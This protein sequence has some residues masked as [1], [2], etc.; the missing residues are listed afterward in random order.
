MTKRTPLLKWIFASFALLIATTSCNKDLKD[1]VD[2][3]KNRVTTLEESVNLL[4][5]AI[6]NGKLI[7]D[8]SPVAPTSTTPGGWLITFSDKTTIPVNHGSKGDTGNTGAT[9]PQG[10][11]PYVWVNNAGNWASNLGSKPVDADNPSYEIKQGGKSVKA[12]GISV[13]VI[14]KDG[15][16]AFEE[17]DVITNTVKN[18]V[19]TTFPFVG[20]KVITAIVETPESVT[21]TID[22]KTYCLAK[23]A[24]FPTSITVIRDKDYVIKGGTVKFDIA[25]NPANSKIYT[26]EDFSLDYEKNYTRAYGL[27]PDFIKIK[28]VEPYDRDGDYKGQYHMT[29]E[30]KESDAGFAKDAAIF[31]VL[32]CTDVEGKLTHI[33]S[34]TPVIMNEKYVSIDDENVKDLEGI[35]M[36]SDETFTDSIYLQEYHQGYVNTITYALAASPSSD[37]ISINPLT[38]YLVPGGDKYKFTV[39]P[40][41]GDNTTVWPTGVYQRHTDV[42]VS[43]S[44]H[45]RAAV[46]AVPAK[47]EIGQPA[48]PGIPEIPA[49]TV[50]KDFCVTVYKVPTDGII[51]TK[52]FQDRWLPN[53]TVDYTLTQT[54]ATAFNDN[55][56][57]TTDWTFAIKTQDLQLH[58]GGAWASTTMD[59]KVAADVTKFN[60]NGS[61]AVSYKLL[62]TIDAG[63]YQMILTITATSKTVRPAEMKQSREFK[64][65]LQFNV[66]APKFQILYKGDH[67]LIGSGSDTYET[68]VLKDVNVSFLFDVES[69]KNISKATDVTPNATPLAYDYDLTDPRHGAQGIRFNPYPAVK[70]PVVADWGSL[71]LIK[72][73]ITANVKLA[74]GQSL[75]VNIL[76]TP[77]NEQHS[78]SVLYVQYTRLNLTLVTAAKEDFVGNYNAMV[79]TGINIAAS[80]NFTPKATGNKTLDPTMIKTIAYSAI[81]NVQ[82]AGALPNG[83]AGKQI[84]KVDAATGM[85][86]S[87]DGISWE[88]PDA[89]LF[90]V[91]RVTYTDIWGNSAFK[92]VKV[93]VKSN[94]IPSLP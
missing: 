15:Y 61:F 80:S 21:F 40:F 89:I 5:Q 6:K 56:Y 54:L 50:D 83:L 87:I 29:L 34:S 20:G 46:P 77:T 37:P 43:V 45:G 67:T 92:D 36:F 23:A 2:E 79:T 26:K 33:V 58:S 14:N 71:M 28:S 32:N 82:S 27:D 72:K 18:T 35:V 86:T 66:V 13:R 90:Q 81:G 9:G 48:T 64:V 75:P 25:V 1:D 41:R 57:K 74:T 88:N 44:D 94:S 16:V 11:T 91:F 8:V 24:V 93:H 7:T 49:K 38:R 68:T 65:K 76:C 12:N 51:L 3:L 52:D 42:T 4:D 78:T 10:Q 85:V 31:I 19:T 62:P 73:P 63:K 53:T 69:N 17:Y 84:L 59:K 22:S 39:I 60:T 70:A 47:P 30:W 55:G